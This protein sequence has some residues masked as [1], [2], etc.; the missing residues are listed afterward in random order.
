MI[1][2]IWNGSMKFVK[3]VYDN[4]LSAYASQSAYFII[5]SFIPFLLLLMTLIRYLP[6][7]NEFSTDGILS[8][9]PET[10]KVF[11]MNII[12]EVYAKTG[13]VVPIT[14]V[15]AL[16]SAGKGFQALT[17]G[18][19]VINGVQETR[20]YFYMRIRSIIY[21]IIFIIAIVLTLILLVFGRSIQ[22][23]LIEF[24]PFVAE[25]TN[26]ILRFSTIITM[27]VLAFAFLVF[28]TFLPNRKQS[29]KNQIPGALFS[30]VA[31]SAFSFGFSMYL[32]Y[33]TGFSDMYGSLTTIIL[34]ML[35]LYFCMYIFL[36]G[37]EIN[38][39]LEV[40][41]NV[42]RVK[43]VWDDMVEE[44][45]SETQVMIRD[46]VEDKMREIESNKAPQNR[47]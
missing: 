18:L 1:R 3:R 37:A 22:R 8:G 5:L 12:G 46:N 19:N 14:A 41:R 34:F 16:W 44:I 28:Y 15:V 2:K 29:M 47:E 20:N 6:I 42:D 11:L 40:P 43:A 9:I 45:K 35:W 23:I 39:I 36:L 4:H 33:F 38:V 13:A 31:W 27:F 30:S 25:I 21:T 10:M 26:F 24:W 17:N 32:E 7:A